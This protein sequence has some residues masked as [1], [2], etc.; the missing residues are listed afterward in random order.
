MMRIL[1]RYP[2]ENAS[3]YLSP[4]LYHRRGP[5][6]EPITADF[7]GSDDP[8]YQVGGVDDITADDGLYDIAFSIDA[9]KLKVEDFDVVEDEIDIGTINYVEALWGRHPNRR[10]WFSRVGS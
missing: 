8:G 1:I 3:A 10:E 9:V 5:D 6:P 4:V 7:P 2:E